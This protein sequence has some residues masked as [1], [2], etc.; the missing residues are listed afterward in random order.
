MKNN[1]IKRNTTNI[2]YLNKRTGKVEVIFRDITYNDS[3]TIME[4]GELYITSITHLRTPELYE[5]IEQ[6]VPEGVAE[7][8]EQIKQLYHELNITYDLL[9]IE[10]QITELKNE[11]H[12]RVDKYYKEMINTVEAA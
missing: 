10:K 12:R 9:R 1:V 11:I 6:G 3:W 8:K 5:I 7:M 2:K 4:D